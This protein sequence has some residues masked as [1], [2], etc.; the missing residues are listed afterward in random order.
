MRARERELL[1]FMS[2]WVD[3]RASQWIDAVTGL[4]GSGPAYVFLLAEALRDAGVKAGLPAD[5]ATRLARATV[6]GSGAHVAHGVD[7]GQLACRGEQVLNRQRCRE[8]KP[9]DAGHRHTFGIQTRD[10]E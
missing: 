10:D 5:L 7:A 4:S 2:I 3:R 1:S 8:Q 6:A 9:V